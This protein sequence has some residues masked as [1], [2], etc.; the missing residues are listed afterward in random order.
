MHRQ[1]RHVV[2]G[3][4]YPVDRGPRGARQFRPLTSQAV[5]RRVRQIVGQLVRVMEFGHK[6][7]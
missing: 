2:C 4:D 6:R 3:D 1:A 7:C 5:G